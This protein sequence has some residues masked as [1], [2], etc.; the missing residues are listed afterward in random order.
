P[1]GSTATTGRCACTRSSARRSRCTDPRCTPEPTA[2]RPPHRPTP[3]VRATTAAPVPRGPESVPISEK[4]RCSQPP[5]PS[6]H[7]RE[8]EE[9]GHAAPRRRRSPHV[10]LPPV[11]STTRTVGVTL[12]LL[13]P[14]QPLNPRDEGATKESRHVP[15]PPRPPRPP[16]LRQEVPRVGERGMRVLPHR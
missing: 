2:L 6:P 4:Q 9:G 14:T 10:D 3:T 16:A 15:K 1:A 5:R 12:S 7:R 8:G 13:P 11:R